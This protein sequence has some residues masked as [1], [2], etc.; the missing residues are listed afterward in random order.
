VQVQGRQL[1]CMGVVACGALVVLVTALRRGDAAM[2][3]HDRELFLQRRQS[4]RGIAALEFVELG[5]LRL[6]ETERRATPGSDAAP[7]DQEILAAVQDFLQHRFGAASSPEL[8]LEWCR[9]RGYTMRSLDD[10]RDIWW[11]DQA[12]STYLGGPPPEGATAEW[13]FK[14]CMTGADAYQ[15]GR[16]RIMGVSVDPEW[17]ETVS[18]EVTRASPQL[19]APDTWPV[20]VLALTGRVSSSQS[21]L[22]H[23]ALVS[24]RLDADG[25]AKVGAA[26]LVAEFASGDRR[27]IRIGV[28]YDAA[29]AEWIVSSITVGSVAGEESVRC[30]F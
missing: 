19:A 20:K 14:A 15:D 24:H 30:E 5:G 10:L 11:V 25:R 9:S 26:W 8:Y 7:L 16:A 4:E 28:A 23:P 17:M 6:S 29:R 1:W 2:N 21:W 27:P 3:E 12:Y 22:D 13:L 18:G